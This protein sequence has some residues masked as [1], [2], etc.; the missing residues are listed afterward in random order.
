LP[1]NPGEESAVAI[2]RPH[3]SERA[4]EIVLLPELE[5]PEPKSEASSS[6]IQLDKMGGFVATI[7]LLP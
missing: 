7:E 4:G 3:R 6:E 5:A 1:I 2:V